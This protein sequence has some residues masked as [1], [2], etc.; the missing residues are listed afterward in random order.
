MLNVVKTKVVIEGTLKPPP[1]NSCT[2]FVALVNNSQK[3]RKY[4]GSFGFFHCRLL[5]G[6]GYT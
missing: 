1:G 4:V 3:L 6:F 5:A 2:G